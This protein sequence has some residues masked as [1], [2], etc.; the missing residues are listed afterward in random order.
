MGILYYRT[1]P[2]SD[3][4][5]LGTLGPREFLL[6]RREG[7]QFRRTGQGARTT[8]TTNIGSVIT[9]DIPQKLTKAFSSTLACSIQTL[10]AFTERLDY[11]PYLEQAI[12]EIGNTQI[13]AATMTPKFYQE[14]R[15]GAP[16]LHAIFGAHGLVAVQR[17]AR[18]AARGIRLMF[19]MMRSDDYAIAFGHPSIIILAAWAVNECRDMPLEL[20]TLNPMEGIL[21][22]STKNDDILFDINKITVNPLEE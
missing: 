16:Q 4:D 17:F 2:D 19:D 8:I 15:R 9:L 11:S 3:G 7:E 10:Y 12:G 1:C 14:I 6:A 20:R 5:M 22:I 21:F 13:L 18:I